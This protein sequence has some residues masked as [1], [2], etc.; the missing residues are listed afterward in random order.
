[1]KGIKME[2][3]E[4]WL[5]E[6][7]EQNA[8]RDEVE[9]YIKEAKLRGDPYAKITLHIQKKHPEITL[10]LVSKWG[11]KMLGSMDNYSK[12]KDGSLYKNVFFLRVDKKT[13]DAF[14]EA[15]ERLKVDLNQKHRP[16]DQ[17]I[18]TDLLDK[19]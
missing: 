19:C 17:E 10:S 2:T 12:N 3:K 15:R 13:Y 1:M 14:Q 4:P 9:P 5:I 16:S 7:E 18:I 11:L 6:W 8:I